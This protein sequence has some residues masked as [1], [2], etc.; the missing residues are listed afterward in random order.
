MA[1]II[2]DSSIWVDPSTMRGNNG[3]DPFLR[4]GIVKSVFPTEDNTQ[5]D[6]RYLVALQDRNDII[7]V[8]CRMLR[9]FGGVYNYEDV[10]Y[11]G[12]NTNGT[13]D[14]VQNWNAKAGDDVIVV[15]FNGE[16]REGII[17]GGIT[18]AARSIS[19]NPVLGPQYQSEFN[20]I[21]TNIN[22]DG[23]WTLTFKG[24]PTNLSV[25][26]NTPSGPIPAPTYDTTVGSS[27]MKFDKTG[28]WTTSDNATSNPQSIFIDKANGMITT[29]S[30]QIS[31]VM[32][33]SAQS[34]VLTCQDLTIN[35]SNSI[36]ETT[37]SYTLMC[38]DLTINASNSIT[39][40]TSN[41]TLMA[42][43]SAKFVSPKIAIGFGPVELL[44]QLNLL[45]TALGLVT[46]IPLT[47][48]AATPEWPAVVQIQTQIALITGSL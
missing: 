37:T 34:V 25:L 10:V 9:R 48:L 29:T 12:Y 43:I 3:K 38:Q 5:D 27:F 40:T 13:P 18:H 21:N 11:R 8:T 36:T 2:K 30:G 22:A 39:E 7:N 6:V 16:G 20:G 4:M 23:E 44:M 28:S 24:Q 41:Y 42:N 47:P 15:F 14:I 33:K 17:L 31:L 19:L 1:D 32:T 26:N 45:I 35:S 46:P